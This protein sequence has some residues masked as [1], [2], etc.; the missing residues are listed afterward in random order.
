MMI[1]T[2]NYGNYYGSS[3]AAVCNVLAG[4]V[5]TT[6]NVD[7]VQEELKSKCA[8]GSDDGKIDGWSKFKSALWGIGKSIVNGVKSIISSPGNFLKAAALTALC[9]IPGVNVVAG[10]VIGAIGLYKGI[11]GLSS[12]IG[13]ANSATTDAEAQAAW[14]N[15]GSSGFQIAAS[16]VGTCASF[17]GIGRMMGNTS[18]G[19]MGAVK[20]VGTGIKSLASHPLQ[21]MGTA[22]KTAGQSA[23][24]QALKGVGN[25]MKDAQGVLGKVK[26]GYNA[27]KDALAN[28][29]LG[30]LFKKKDGD[31]PDAPTNADTPDAPSSEIDKAAADAKARI[32][33]KQAKAQR[34]AGAKQLKADR[35]AYKRQQA[36]IKSGKLV[37]NGTK[38]VSAKDGL[39]K[40]DLIANPDGAIAAT[41]AAPPSATTGKYTNADARAKLVEHGV[42]NPSWSLVTKTRL[43]ANR[44]LSNASRA[45][46]KEFLSSEAV[47]QAAYQATS[48]G[49]AKFGSLAGVSGGQMENPNS[50]D[51]FSSITEYRKYLQ[52]KA[53]NEEYY[54]Q[55]KQNYSSPLF[56]TLPSYGYYYY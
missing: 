2:T 6:V 23:F 30:K 25:A 14:E 12:A 39:V 33:A 38:V 40:G 3:T 4:Q 53:Q 44:A 16:A 31:T 21:T 45:A 50:Q 15:I 19:V 13:N 28:T 48:T 51:Y 7:A 46:F 8:D 10:A 5:S 37:P 54:E 36:D 9:F 43:S 49:L 42:D 52:Q 26:A 41:S 35:S 11:E 20:S 55:M 32:D 1:N 22:L 18:T 34:K 27:T 17:A 56:G 24:G 47:L 29:K